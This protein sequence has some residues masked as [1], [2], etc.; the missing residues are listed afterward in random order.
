MKNILSITLT[1]SIALLSLGEIKAQEAT[2][3]NAEP[4]VMSITNHQD[5][6]NEMAIVVSEA[7]S[8]FPNFKYAFTFN[9]DGVPVSVKIKGV[10]DKIAKS[11]LEAQL[12]DLQMMRVEMAWNSDKLMVRAD[13]GKQGSK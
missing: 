4:A 12:L 7:R 13:H 6:V 10:N 1:A 5:V 3:V 2:F 9:E 8:Y 11:F